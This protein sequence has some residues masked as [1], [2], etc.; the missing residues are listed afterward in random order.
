MAK[1]ATNSKIGNTTKAPLQWQLKSISRIRQ[2]IQSWNRALNLARN[3]EFTQNYQL[4]LLYNEICIDAH[5]T[6]QMANRK[7]QLWSSDFTVTSGGKQNDAAIEALTNM[8]AFQTIIEGIQDSIYYGYSLLQLEIKDGELVVDDIPRTNVIPQTG[9]FF[10]DYG[11]TNNPI[12][13]RQLP[14]FGTWLLEIN[15]ISLAKSDYGLL[16][17]AVPH[18]LFKRFAESCWSEL[19]EIYGIPPRVLKTN[20]QDAAMMKRAQSMLRDMGAAAYFII[21]EME[22]LDFAQGVSTDGSVYQNLINLCDNQNSLLISGAIIGQDTK[23]GNRSKDQTAQEILWLR[24]LADMRHVQQHMNATVMPAL[25]KHGIVPQGSVFSYPKAEDTAQ[26]FKF[27][28]PFINSK[29]YRIPIDWL[30]DKFGIEVEEV[31]AADKGKGDANPSE[32][33][34]NDQEE[35]DDPNATV[36]PLKGF[37]D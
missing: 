16:N 21:D 7:E 5:L 8:P 1:S 6:S 4:Q 11:D 10:T 34:P 13:Y 15:S 25:A 19:A 14:E 36:D 24:V 28:Q 22:A 31:K 27:I 20:T 37:F 3:V 18:V 12:H 26:L 32:E 9:Q 29:K 33:D 2:D 17:K 30:R 23:Y 35:K